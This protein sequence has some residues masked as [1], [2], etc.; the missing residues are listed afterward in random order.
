MR[1]VAWKIQVGALSESHYRAL[2]RRQCRLARIACDDAALDYLITCLHPSHG[3]ALLAS[4]PR[5]LLSR[6]ADFA[7]F[8]GAQ[9]RLTLPALEQA[10]MSMFAGCISGASAPSQPSVPILATCGDPLLERIS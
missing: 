1:R 6:I 9:P 7:S 2:F 5:E 10:W 8:A 4:Y 3:R